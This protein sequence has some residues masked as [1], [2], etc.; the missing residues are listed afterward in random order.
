M[1]DPAETAK[2]KAPLPRNAFQLVVVAAQ[3]AKQ[4]MAGAR[5]RIEPGAHRF[6]RVALLES[7][8]GLVSWSVEDAPRKVDDSDA[9]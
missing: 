1:S 8:A 6:T 3:R 5:P 4:L 7:A 2:P 9:K